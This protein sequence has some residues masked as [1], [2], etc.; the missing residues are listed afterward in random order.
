MTFSF[1]PFLRWLPHRLG[2]QLALPVSLL[3]AGTV[4]VYTWVTAS[5]EMNLA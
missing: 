3:F 2:S 1:R 5:A 4:F